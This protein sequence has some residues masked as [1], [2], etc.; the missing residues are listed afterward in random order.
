MKLVTAIIYA[1]CLALQS[2][3]QS[4]LPPNIIRLSDVTEKSGIRFKH[5]TGGSGQA[6]IVE[7][8]A[9]GLATFDYNN[10]GL[11]DIFFLNGRSL[12]G[13]KPNP[14]CGPSAG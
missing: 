12:K 3:A 13:S 6:Y 10:D 14:Q 9:A 1:L 2:V 8:A 11:I 5:D 7:S 4:P